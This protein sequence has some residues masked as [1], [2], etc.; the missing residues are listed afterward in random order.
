MG[1]YILSD[2]ILRDSKKTIIDKLAAGCLNR[3]LQQRLLPV[4]RC[5]QK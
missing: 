2:L 3:I 4:I 5:K 1:Q